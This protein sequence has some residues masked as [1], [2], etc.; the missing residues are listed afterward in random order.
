MS[1]QPHDDLIR[2]ERAATARRK[3][4]VQRRREEGAAGDKTP[5]E[6]GDVGYDREQEAPG[7]FC[8]SQGKSTPWGNKNSLGCDPACTQGKS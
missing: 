8:A 1:T 3:G 2:A 5:F 6:E 7:D 4:C